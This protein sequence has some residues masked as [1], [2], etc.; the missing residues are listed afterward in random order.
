[1]VR[2]IWM[3]YITWITTSR[4][5]FYDSM[6]QLYCHGIAAVMSVYVK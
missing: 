3:S 4:V 5:S 6:V 1:M 2:Q